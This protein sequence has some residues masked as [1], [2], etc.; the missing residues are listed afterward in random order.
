MAGLSRLHVKDLSRKESKK[1]GLSES[2]SPST[3][4]ILE[5]KEKII[6]ELKE[7]IETI[8]RGKYMWESTFDAITD[9]VVIISSDYTI[10]RANRAASRISKMDVRELNGTRCYE[11]LAGFTSPCTGCPLPS[12]LKRQTDH[13]GDLPRFLKSSR[14]FH[15]NA[16]ALRDRDPAD[17]LRAVLHYRD[18]TEEKE[19][20]HKLLHSE[21]M[22]AIG[23]LAGG[24]A[25]EINNP[26]GGILA[27]TQLIMRD[28]GPDHVNYQD[29]KEIEEAA[30]RCKQIV[31]DLLDFSRQNREENMEPLQIND[32]INKVLTLVQVQA[33]T[34]RVEMITDL[35]SNLP[36]I[37]GNFYK[38]QQVFLNLITNA[39]HAMKEGGTL[40][41][42][43]Y[44][45][46]GGKVGASVADTGTGIPEN[47]Q[48]RIFDPYFTTKDHGQGTGLGL[49]ITYGL[50]R[51]HEGAIEVKSQEGKGTVF[52]LSFPALQNLN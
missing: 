37:R 51:E 33:R 5:E 18:V 6:V 23:T 32:V 30:M 12:T 41:V 14:Q 49:S 27:F 45:T 42:K 1:G 16:Y 7:L 52:E 47:I 13:S 35:T 20:Q 15:A 22:A 29:L 44:P 19:L 50:V 31:Q 10:Q 28:L 9:P 46:E 34:S 24:V 11:T 36:K 2:V 3:E 21:K 4:E 38:L 40:T 48:D 25:H 17:N 39:Y 26:L 8:S 43:T